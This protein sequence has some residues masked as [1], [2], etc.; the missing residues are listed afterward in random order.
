MKHFTQIHNCMLQICKIADFYIVNDVAV[1][2]AV[3]LAAVSCI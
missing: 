2:H 1:F 3:Q